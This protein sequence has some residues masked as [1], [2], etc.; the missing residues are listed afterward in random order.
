MNLCEIFQSCDTI[1]AL[2]QTLIRNEY[3]SLCNFLYKYALV[4]RS[5]IYSEILAAQRHRH[6]VLVVTR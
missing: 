4:C 6:G 3:K 5:D 1:L 2:T